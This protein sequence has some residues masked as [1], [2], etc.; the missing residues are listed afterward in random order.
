MADNITIIKKKKVSGGGGHHGGAWKVAYADFVTA[1]MAFFLL[2]WLLNAT[3]E[4]QRKGLA[5]YFSPTIPLHRSSGGGDGPLTGS[6]V[7]AQDVLPS[8]GQS[9]AGNKAE[10]Q[11]EEGTATATSEESNPEQ[12]DNSSQTAQIVTTPEDFELLQ[13][14]FLASSGESEVE[15]D[16]YQHIRTRI[17]D[18]GLIIELIDS[19]QLPLF[20]LGSDAPTENLGRMLGAIAP[21]LKTIAN[22]IALRGNAFGFSRA[23]APNRNW[24]MSVN[25]SLS[26]ARLLMMNGIEDAKIARVV[27]VSDRNPEYPHLADRRN[28]RIEL[29]VLR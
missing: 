1:M 13:D 25:R 17:T 14:I 2:M 24:L 10:S 27:G 12:S 23:D 29:I 28:N 7:F 5:D 15:D 20:E 26:T 22:P 6:S 9:G 19:A 18:E 4:K 3:T 21:V 8:V 11:D 16:M